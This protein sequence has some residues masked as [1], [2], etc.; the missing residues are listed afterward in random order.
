MMNSVSTLS[1]FLFLASGI[2]TLGFLFLATKSA[3]FIFWVGLALF[4]MQGIAGFNDFYSDFT[5]TPPRL[6]FL[7]GPSLLL[8]AL[9]F[10]VAKFRAHGDKLNLE[11]LILLNVVRIPVEFGLFSLHQDGLVPEMMTYAGYN[12]DIFSGITAPIIWWFWKK[13]GAAAK[14]IILAWNTVCL[15]LV[16]TIATIAVGAAPTPFQAWSFDFPNTV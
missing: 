1:T 16:L 14:N 2:L 6:I 7:A 5:Q 8:V 10:S 15:I 12:L 11:W 3:K 13:K 9:F 4:I